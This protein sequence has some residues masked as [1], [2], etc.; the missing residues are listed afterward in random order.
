[1]VDR[2][3]KVLGKKTWESMF[4]PIEVVSNSACSESGF[5]SMQIICKKWM[6]P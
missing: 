1:M 3:V 6:E 4:E 2:A 5:L